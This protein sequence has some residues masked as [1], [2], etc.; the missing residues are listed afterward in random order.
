MLAWAL[1]ARPRPASMLCH[2]TIKDFAIIPALEIDFEAGFTA[3]TGE[4]GA[5]KSMLVDAIGLLLGDRA[6]SRTVRAR[7]ERAELSA[8]FDLAHNR[9]AR[10]WLAEADLGT[11]ECL[12][13]RVIGANGRSR[14]WIN[15]VP[16][17]LQQMAE[18][19]A[20]LVEIHGQN[21]HVRL[22]STRHQLELLDHG[23]GHAGELAQVREAWQ[24]WQAL[25][26]RI[27]EAAAH[28]AIGAE[29]RQFLD[30]QLRELEQHAL[31]PERVQALENEHRLLARGGALVEA[32]QLALEHLEED[33]RGINPRLHATA[34]RLQPFEALDPR[35][36]EV[37]QMLSEAV[38]NCQEAATTLQGALEGVDLSPERLDT[39][40]R[41]LGTLG[42]LARKHRMP[43]EELC[44]VRDR[45]AE[46]LADADDFEARREALE[47]ERDAALAT[48]RKASAALS[49]RRQAHGAELSAAVTALMGELGMPGGQ[50]EMVLSHDPDA[51]PSPRGDDGIE[52]RVSANPGI[53]PGPLASI[54]SGG[55]LSRISLAIKV[56]AHDSRDAMTHIFDEVDAGIGGDT[57]NAVGRLLQRLAGARQVLCVTHLA[58]VAVCATHQVHVQKTTA[59]DSTAV[60]TR[61]LRDDARVREIARMLGG[62][63]SDQS[64]LH[65][66]E[67]LRA[68][69]P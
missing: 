28:A 24:A 9:A 29:E 63:V 50:F 10:D 44:A 6:D 68:G 2:L 8:V 31:E 40:T 21:E 13:R 16:V 51:A 35:L 34:G 11:K 7:A 58:Q 5:G 26:Q 14:A 47:R 59:T 54:A 62:K 64:R 55:E 1:F 60:D 57:A 56:A 67:L 39:V 18:L 19:G 36:A 38:I 12:L 20:R 53:P 66:E 52:L 43:L 3:I 46:R 23:G 49:G 22:T 25:R 45:L 41:Q 69:Q 27:D 65:A 37:R 4:T 61:L 15:G 42:D 30:Y 32:L 33:D 17:T 48:Y